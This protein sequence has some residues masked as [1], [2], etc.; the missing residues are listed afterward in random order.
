M[1]NDA[2]HDNEY[3][4]TS[5]N[6]DIQKDFNLRLQPVNR[7]QQTI[8]L[9][10]CILDIMQRE[11]GKHWTLKELANEANGPRYRGKVIN[12]MNN[13]IYSEIAEYSIQRCM[14]AKK[15]NVFDKDANGRWFLQ[16]NNANDVPLKKKTDLDG[17]KPYDKPNT[18]SSKKSKKLWQ[19]L[20]EVMKE[21]EEKAWTAAELADYLNSPKYKGTIHY[22]TFSGKTY[23]TISE[24]SV[25]VCL[26][27]KPNIFE[28]IE[29][30]MYIL[31]K[32]EM[33]VEVRKPKKRKKE[34]EEE[35][36]FRW[37]RKKYLKP[38]YP[39]PTLSCIL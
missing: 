10:E 1:M 31:R 11:S 34:E 7:N 13:K 19:Y 16:K 18:S 22:N 38:I 25:R 24:T 36:G 33:K 23:D 27:G 2:S 14:C 26:S 15:Q 6:K 20:V 8:K 39:E 3:L 12:M 37:T 17:T 21:N 35:E 32:Q 5:D 30:D 29:N 9:F 4:S 28:K